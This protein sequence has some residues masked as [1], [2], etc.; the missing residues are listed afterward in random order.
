MPNSS[1]KD[2]RYAENLRHEGKFQEALEL[3]NS[4]EKK[5]NII[6]ADQLS[7]F[8]SKGKILTLFQRHMETIRVGKLAYSLSKSLGRTNETITSLLFRSNCLFLGQYDKAL[9]Y[10]SEAEELLKSLSEVSPSYLN[11]QKRNILFRKS[12]AHSFKGELDKALKE[13]LEC[14]ELQEKLGSKSDIAY[15]LQLIG[16]TYFGKGEYD[17]AFEYASRSK[18]IF[19][20]KRDNT[21]LATTLAI[22][23]DISYYKGNFDQ[24]IEFCKKSLSSKMI[25]SRTKLDNVNVLGQIYTNR[26]ELNKAL[27]Y[28]N[29]GI[30]LAEKENIFNYFINFQ[31]HVGRIYFL[32]GEYD[33][34]IEYLEPS[35]SLAEKINDIMAITY[36]LL[37]LVIIKLE[38][39]EYEEINNYLERLKQL[40]IKINSKI[41]TNCYLLLKALLLKRTGGSR[42]RVEAESLLK[43]VSAS[44]TNLTIRS[45]ALIYL[46]EFYLEE[47]TLFEDTEVFKEIIPL[48]EELYTLSEEQGT[49]AY[50]AEAK[51]LKAKLALIQMD[52]EEARRLLTQSQRV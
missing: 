5:G 15:T 27:K 19:E 35:L 46:C 9:K 24:A 36:A 34:A 8:I 17:L 51:L 12:W 49:Y 3:I 16:N 7:L 31:G 41:I 4:I 11:R 10:L 40:E 43:Q 47:L 33:H 22:L 38:K 13:A 1:P 28:L 21:G 25:S 52:F 48:V 26:G 32:K 6:P 39:Q 14:L 37:H 29:Q 18:I 42:S 23:G 30:V 50:L 45:H 2:L 20:D 44:E